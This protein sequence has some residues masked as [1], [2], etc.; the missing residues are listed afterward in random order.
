[1]KVAYVK[2][3]NGRAY[4]SNCLAPVHKWDTMCDFCGALFNDVVIRTAE[5]VIGRIENEMQEDYSVNIVDYTNVFD[6]NEDSE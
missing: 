5:E 4:C 2:E 3:I 1:M 6:S